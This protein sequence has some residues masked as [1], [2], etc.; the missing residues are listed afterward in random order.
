MKKFLAVYPFKRLHHTLMLAFLLLSLLPLTLVALFFLN[1]YSQDLQKQSTSHLLSVRDSKQQQINDYL[2]AQE[3]EVLGFVASEL[4]YASGGHFYGLIDAF[5]RLR[6]DIEQARQYAQ[7]RYLPESGNKIKTPVAKDDPNYSATERYRLLHQRYHRAYQALLARADF[8]DAL[9]VDKQGNVTYSVKKHANYGTNLIT[10]PFRDTS[11]GHT[12]S[13]LT[14]HSQKIQGKLDPT[15]HV[16][17]SDFSPEQ[18][19]IPVAWLG[20]PIIQQGYLHSYALFRLP[21]QA[22]ATLMAPR[23][24]NGIQTLLVGKDGQV[25]AQSATSKAI[26]NSTPVMDKALAGNTGVTRYQSPS[27]NTLLAAYTPIDS[28]GL[29]WGLVAEVPTQVAFARVHQLEQLFIVAMLLATLAVVVASHY[30][31]NF[32]TRPLLQLTWAAEKVSAG[33]L[34][35]QIHHTR[36]PD[37]VGRLA[38]S[39][40]RMRHAIREKIQ[41]I[42]QQ[43]QTL[44][45]NLTII[46][47]QNQE[48][49]LANTLKDE[50]LATT[51]HELR[52]PLHGMIGIAEAMIDGANGPISRD[53]QYQLSIIVNS[54]QRLAKLVDDLLDYHK[55]RYGQLDLEQCP[56]DVNAMTQLVL[57]LAKHLKKDKP[58]EIINQLSDSPVWVYADPQR[59]EQVMYNLLGNAIKF[60]D[61]GKIVISADTIDD[62]IRVQVV[63]TGKGIPAEQLS[64]VFEPLAQAVSGHYHYQH[65]AGLGLSISRQLIEL[66]GGQLYVSSQ[67]Q[68]G[69]TFSFTL[70]KAH[71]MPALT[72]ET[73]QHISMSE[74]IHPLDADQRFPDPAEASVPAPAEDAL[75]IMVVDDEP[76]NQQILTSFLHMEGY[77]VSTASDG[78]TAIDNVIATPPDLVLL[79]V[80]MPGMSGFD[81]C[82]QLRTHFDHAA[83][84]II[85]LTAL[86]QPDDRV[87][88]FSVGANDYLSKPFD[89]RELAARIATHLT[90]SQAEQRR[91]ENQRLEQALEQSAQQQ[92]SLLE[93]QS[94]LISQLSLAPEAMLG[95]SRD[96]QVRFVNEAAARLFKRDKEDVKRMHGH[97]LVTAPDHAQQCERYQGPLTAFID[98]TPEHLDGMLL[99]FPAESDIDSLYVINNDSPV[100]QT[101][102]QSLESAIEALSGYALG[103]DI[104]QLD[105]LKAMGG[106]FEALAEKAEHQQESKIN[107]RRQLIVEAM[108]AGLDYWEE[109]TGKTKFDFAEQSGLWRVYL[110]RSSLQ[111]RTLDKYLLLETLPKTPRWRTVLNSIRFI[112]DHCDKRSTTRTQLESYYQQLRQLLLD[113]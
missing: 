62:R 81:V 6:P 9:L 111:T 59:L 1:A 3:A 112:L 41:L 25:R 110:D 11:L 67:P 52:T 2:N 86:N 88:G 76:T 48:L 56:V 103:G 29:K 38:V 7:R 46:K 28:H 109:A 31:S 10:G 61:A 12:F 55:M 71:E 68:V 54:G 50:F 97:A 36:R 21:N 106:E 17:I 66:M 79:D 23:E 57:S 107:T 99:R 32:I 102:I 16:V 85:M 101:R 42:Q 96:G 15:P 33:D 113:D 49:Q 64:R 63:D 72:D 100:S 35:T 13:A 70:A 60:T 91:Q 93:T 58:L 104:R 74:H 90:A 94:W 45:A 80:L 47:A 39:F 95:M 5:R 19:G 22:L 83:L 105:A 30:V 44:E 26:T 82:E 73:D 69:T 24:S 87:Y 18:D 37:E 98:G 43:N 89:K 75:H 77:R 27:G 8:D 65:G 20:A 4:A 108:I 40:A 51:S 34:D 92:A 84:P 53:H 78:R 14:Q